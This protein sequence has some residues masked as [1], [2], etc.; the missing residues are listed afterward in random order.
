MSHS[1]LVDFFFS[2]ADLLDTHRPAETPRAHRLHTR[3]AYLFFLRVD[4]INSSR[5]ASEYSVLLVIIRD[6]TSGLVK[7]TQG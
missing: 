3:S 5:L 4:G 6:E 7:R 2:S 1:L